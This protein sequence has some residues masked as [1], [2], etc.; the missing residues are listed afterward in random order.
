MLL[1]IVC[2]THP[3]GCFCSISKACPTLWGPMDCSTPG[4]P[5]LVEQTV[6]QG[7]LKFMS[8]ESVIASNHLILCRPPLL[9]SIFPSIRVFSNESALRIGWP[10]YWSFSIS[11]SKEYSE[12][13]SFRIDCNLIS[14]VSQGFSRVLHPASKL[15]NNKLIH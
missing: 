13:I 12:L 2:L 7:L 3:V 8:L 11:P 14:F 5:V 6:S 1:L 4:F 10:K 9:P 15:S